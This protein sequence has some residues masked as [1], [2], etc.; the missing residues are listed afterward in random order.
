[1]RN[2]IKQQRS[3]HDNTL[4]NLSPPP[5]TICCPSGLKDTEFPIRVSSQS[6][7]LPVRHR[8]HIHQFVV[9]SGNNMLPVGTEGDRR[10]S[11]RVQ[12]AMQPPSSQTQ[13]TPQ[14]PPVAGL[15]V[16]ERTIFVCPT[17][18]ATS[19]LADTDHTFNN[20][21]ELPKTI[22]CPSGLKATE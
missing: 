1:M 8:P 22:C 20:L 19:F 6:P 12:P 2:V 17:S 5:E 11:I 16:T 4:T 10:N 7:Q 15:K 21:S 18:D 13:T 14:S 3:I 9:T